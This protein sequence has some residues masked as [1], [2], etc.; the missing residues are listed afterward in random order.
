MFNFQIINPP[1]SF[2]IKEKIMKAIFN[3]V[4]NIEKAKQSGILNIV[5]V[6]DG[7]IQEL[8]K[9]Y[10][11]IDTSTD[12]LSFHYFDDFS[13]LDKEEIAWEIILSEEKIIV[14]WQEYKLWSELECY[15]LVIHSIFH[16]LWYDHEKDNDYLIMKEKEEQVW[17]ILFS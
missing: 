13:K 14:Q 4:Q 1:K 3:E 9:N 17:S 11:K 12:V 15:K 10:R 8:N 5:F 7:T 2:I 6:S 16:I